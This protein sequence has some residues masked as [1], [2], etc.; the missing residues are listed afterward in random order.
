MEI[1]T[2]VRMTCRSPLALNL[3]VEGTSADSFCVSHR[4]GWRSCSNCNGVNWARRH[5]RTRFTPQL[6]TS[7]IRKPR[8]SLLSATGYAGNASVITALEV[9][10]AIRRKRN[11]LFKDAFNASRYI[12]VDLYDRTASS[13]RRNWA[14]DHAL[15]LQVVSSVDLVA[16]GDLVMVSP[17]LSLSRRLPG[18]GRTPLRSRE[19]VQADCSL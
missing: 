17:R 16:N 11:C 3:A 18:I 15:D 19:P 9:I 8:Q 6:R 12:W 13:E 5:T 2:R 1:S 4:F 10:D 14:F 7:G